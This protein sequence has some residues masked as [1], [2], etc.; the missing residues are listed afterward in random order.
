VTQKRVGF[1]NGDLSSVL[2]W[3]FVADRRVMS[4]CSIAVEGSPKRLTERPEDGYLQSRFRHRITTV[5]NNL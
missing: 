4:M 2:T 5:R 3:P 1:P